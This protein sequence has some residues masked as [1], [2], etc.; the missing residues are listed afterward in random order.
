MIV[1]QDPN[2][3]VILDVGAQILLKNKTVAEIL[4]ELG[5]K[6]DSSPQAVVYFDDHDE[7]IVQKQDHSTEL[8]LFSPFANQL[9]KCFVY[10]DEAHTRGTDLKLPLGSRAAVT[11]GPRLTK[12]RLVQGKQWVH[13][14]LT[15]YLLTLSFCCSLYANEAVGGWPCNYVLCPCRGPP[16][17]IQYFQPTFARTGSD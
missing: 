12:D 6:T 7:L 17:D 14:L 5:G 1:K 8:L 15:V 3:R 10:L 2:I 16:E 4:L 11:L 13:G 9:G